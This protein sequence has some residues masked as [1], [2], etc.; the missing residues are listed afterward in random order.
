M[1]RSG[2][3]PADQAVP[4]RSI[5]YTKPPGATAWLPNTDTLPHRGTSAGGGYSTVE[6]LER[7]AHALLSHKL[8]SPDSTKLLITGK[9]KAGP[10]AKYAYGFAGYAISRR[11]PHH[12]LEV[13]RLQATSALSRKRRGV[14]PAC[15]GISCIETAR[16]PRWG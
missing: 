4:D 3:L 11:I 7:F 14:H 12:C 8:L 10:G 15:L 6:D 2:S 5:G 1:T 13:A 16:V 9:V